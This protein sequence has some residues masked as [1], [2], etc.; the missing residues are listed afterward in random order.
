MPV[1]PKLEPWSTA[2]RTT[3]RQR[4]PSR[5]LSLWQTLGRRR[6]T[7]AVSTP[8]SS[9]GADCLSGRSASKIRLSHRCVLP[10]EHPPRHPPRAAAPPSLAAAKVDFGVLPRGLGRGAIVALAWGIRLAVPGAGGAGPDDWPRD[11]GLVGADRGF[12]GGR[13]FT[14][15]WT[16][17]APHGLCPPLSPK[18]AAAVRVS[19]LLEESPCRAAP[20]ESH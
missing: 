13:G 20:R 17:S 18:A 14:C 4:A 1:T 10:N 8:P 11:R 5:G 7:R 6:G 19:H 9:G 3:W 12:R 16:R 2:R 15:R